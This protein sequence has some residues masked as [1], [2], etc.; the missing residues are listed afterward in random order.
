MRHMPETRKERVERIVRESPRVFA[1]W[2]DAEDS[3]LREEMEE[4]IVRLAREHGRPVSSIRAR[5]GKL[6]GGNFDPPDLV[7]EI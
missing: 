6:Y 7:G 1:A 5:L 2:R 3:Q 4:A